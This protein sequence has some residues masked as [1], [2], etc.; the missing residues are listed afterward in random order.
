MAA[1]TSLPERIGGG[2]NWDYRYTWIRDSAFTIFAFLRIGFTNE[3]EAFMG[4][5]E[6]LYR[7]AAAGE[8]LGCSRHRRTPGDPGVGAGPPGSY[9]GSRPVRIGNDAARQFQLDINGELMDA[10][11][12]YDRYARPVTHDLWVGVR[13]LANWVCAHWQEPDEGI[14]KFATE[15]VTSRSRR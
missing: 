9:C 14:W 11:Y 15:G 1:T 6:R 4:F 5:L 10:I 2:R 12:L 3:A 13:A 7:D 8:A